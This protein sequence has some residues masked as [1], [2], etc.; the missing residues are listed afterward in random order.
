MSFAIYIVWML[1]SIVACFNLTSTIIPGDLWDG[2]ARLI[3]CLGTWFILLAIGAYVLLRANP[4]KPR[5]KF[6]LIHVKL[7]Y[8]DG[9]AR[10]TEVLEIDPAHEMF[11]VGAHINTFYAIL[12]DT[13]DPT[14]THYGSNMTCRPVWVRSLQDVEVTNQTDMLKITIDKDSMPKV[15]YLGPT[16]CVTADCKWSFIPGAKK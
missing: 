12:E 1:G 13:D 7:R 6:H 9:M 15:E 2:V 3:F 11:E 4:D 8:W 16:A 10:Y 14:P 5:G